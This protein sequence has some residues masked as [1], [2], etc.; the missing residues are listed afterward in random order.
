MNFSKFLFKNCAFYGLD[1]RYVAE[2]G[3]VTCKK[4]EPEP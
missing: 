4:S 3:T 2:T 1:R